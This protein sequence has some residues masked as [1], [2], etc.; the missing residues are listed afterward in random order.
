MK[1]N[2]GVYHCRWAQLT[3]QA[4]KGGPRNFATPPSG[5]FEEHNLDR[6]AE[7]VKTNVRGQNFIDVEI[8]MKPPEPARYDGPGCYLS[9]GE[10]RSAISKGAIKL[11]FEAERRSL[12][13][14]SRISALI[15]SHSRYCCARRWPARRL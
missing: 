15:L 6:V 14:T 13:R 12:W 9:Y 8:V 4:A 1:S 5:M 2:H 7:G 10:I 11:R 3:A